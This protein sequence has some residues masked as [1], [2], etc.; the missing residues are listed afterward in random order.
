MTKRAENLR[1]LIKDLLKGDQAA[2][3]E[4]LDIAK[5]EAYDLNLLTENEQQAYQRFRQH[6]AAGGSFS[7]FSLEDLF[8][9]SLLNHKATPNAPRRHLLDNIDLTTISGEEPRQARDVVL[10]RIV[11]KADVPEWMQEINQEF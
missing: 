3:A 11:N 2:A 1:V 7:E 10:G 6:Y 9:C 8:L 4:I 5:R